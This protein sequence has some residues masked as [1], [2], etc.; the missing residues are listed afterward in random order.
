MGE[1]LRG[2]SSP[3]REQNPKGKMAD[4][5]TKSGHGGRGMAGHGERGKHPRRLKQA[6]GKS[7]DYRIQYYV[8]HM[9]YYVLCYIL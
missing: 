8:L 6:R 9:E 7:Q 3:A 5:M 4:V 1:T 2:G